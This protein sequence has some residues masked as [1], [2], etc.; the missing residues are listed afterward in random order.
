MSLA[1]LFYIQYQVYPFIYKLHLTV[2]NFKVYKKH[3]GTLLNC[4]SS[5]TMSGVG[6]E[7]PDLGQASCGA[8]ATLPPY[9]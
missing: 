8:N 5:F 9:V 4:R 7:I 3:L 1:R 2:L 6:P